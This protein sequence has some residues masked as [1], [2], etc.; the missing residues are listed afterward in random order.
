[1][2]VLQRFMRCFASAVII[3]AP[4][5]FGGLAMAIVRRPLADCLTYLCVYTI[6][7]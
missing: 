2:C 6:W 5:D 3:C 4:I 7:R 1:M